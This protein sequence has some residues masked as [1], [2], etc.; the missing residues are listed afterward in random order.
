[1]TSLELTRDSPGHY[2]LG[3]LGSLQTE[4]RFG[5]LIEAGGENWRLRRKL[6]GFGQAITA[7]NAADGS[8][9]ASY[10]PRGFLRLRGIYGGELRLPQR[11]LDWR[12]N[13]Q[14]GRIFT[15]SEA[16]ETLA[17]LEALAEP[18]PV[19]LEAAGAGNLPPLLLLFCCH[20]AKQAVDTARVGAAVGAGTAA[21]GGTAA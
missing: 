12:A 8:L 17:T 2:V 15:V 4:R 7:V 16:G 3:D 5:A 18:T 21:I 1:M 9:V 20:I 6:L 14:L 13:H 19:R 11:A 10:V